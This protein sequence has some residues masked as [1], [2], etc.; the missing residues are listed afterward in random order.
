MADSDGDIIAALLWL[1]FFLGVLCGRA[2]S[3]RR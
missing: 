2:G 1:V 3:G